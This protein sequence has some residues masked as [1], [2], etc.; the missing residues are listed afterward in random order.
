M[1]TVS[2]IRG[3]DTPDAH[4]NSAGYLDRLVDWMNQVVDAFLGPAVGEARHG[5]PA[6][7]YLFLN[8]SYCGALIDSDLWDL[9]TD[10]RSQWEIEDRGDV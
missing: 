10:Q 1:T 3:N 4:Q 2:M 6:E 8:P 5:Q 7:A 9:L